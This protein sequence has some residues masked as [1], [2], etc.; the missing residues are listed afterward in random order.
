MAVTVQKAKSTPKLSFADLVNLR[1]STHE[2]YTHIVAEFRSQT[3]A[4]LVH[5][6]Q[7][8][9]TPSGVTKASCSCE[10][11]TFRKKCKHVEFLKSIAQ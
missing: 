8:F 5:I 4:G 10:G 6:T 11:Y 7:L 1:V 2:G 3:R 9:V